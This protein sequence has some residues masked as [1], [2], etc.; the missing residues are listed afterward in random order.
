MDDGNPARPTEDLSALVELFSIESPARS[1]EDA[2]GSRQRWQ[3]KGPSPPASGC[4]WS[5]AGR[6]TSQLSVTGRVPQSIDALLGMTAHAGLGDGAAD[7]QQLRY[8]M[9]RGH[10]DRLDGRACPR[11]PPWVELSCLL[12]IAR[13]QPAQSS[14]LDEAFSYFLTLGAMDGVAPG[15]PRCADRAGC[16]PTER[17]SVPK[18]QLGRPWSGRRPEG[19]RAALDLGLV[20]VQT[21]CALPGPR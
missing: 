14:I 1:W 21:T 10:C 12:T 13:W 19:K 7:L 16:P 20:A 18:W 15:S 8:L 11:A 5:R 6:G 17:A 2:R 3:R 9:S 4:C